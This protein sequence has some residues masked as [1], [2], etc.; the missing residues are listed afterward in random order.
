MHGLSVKKQLIIKDI[1]SISSSPTI[2]LPP[3]QLKIQTKVIDSTQKSHSEV[4]AYQVTLLK[5]NAPLE[6]L[7]MKKINW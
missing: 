5:I 3:V 6:I 1:L 7:L 4:E 2:S